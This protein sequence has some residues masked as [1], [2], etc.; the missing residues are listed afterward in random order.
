VAYRNEIIN[1]KCGGV[2][3]HG[4]KSRKS[5]AINQMKSGIGE[6]IESWRR[7]K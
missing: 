3:N 4:E 2:S 6:N 1:G 7:R 5:M